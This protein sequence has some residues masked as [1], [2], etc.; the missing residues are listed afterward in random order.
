[1]PIYC[2]RCKECEKREEMVRPSGDR[3]RFP[4][5][6]D[7]GQKMVRD[8]A[9]EAGSKK[10]A[11]GHTYFSSSMGVHPDQVEEEKKLHPDWNFDERG[12]LEVNGYQDQKQKARELGMSIG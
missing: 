10:F 9:T 11:V 4:D 6:P 7:C 3:R 1:M 8:F 12:R 5:C 2:Y